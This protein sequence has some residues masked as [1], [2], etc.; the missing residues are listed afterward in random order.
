MPGLAL[1]QPTLL[2]E[3]W[4]LYKY[5]QIARN[6][7]LGVDLYVLQLR[8]VTHF[9]RQSTKQTTVPAG[10]PSRG[11]DVAVYVF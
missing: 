3:R 8:L 7:G 1:I 2:A 9:V 11:G 5:L 4:V 10:S 6:D